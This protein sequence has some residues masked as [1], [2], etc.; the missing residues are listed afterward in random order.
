MSMSACQIDRCERPVS[1]EGSPF[2]LEN[3]YL[4]DRHTVEDLREQEAR[5]GLL[6]HVIE[7]TTEDF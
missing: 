4:C 1:R 6:P 5:E 3:F 2:V 7:A